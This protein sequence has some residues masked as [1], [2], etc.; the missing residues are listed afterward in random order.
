MTENTRGASLLATRKQKMDELFAGKSFDIVEEV[1]LEG[2][3]RFVT[4]FGNK[5]RNG[6]MLAEVGNPNNTFIIGETMLKQVETD[7]KAINSYPAVTS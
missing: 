1:H 4:P 6:F 2:E 3:D 7:Y 5:G